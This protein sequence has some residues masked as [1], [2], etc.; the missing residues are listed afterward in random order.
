LDGR[1]DWDGSVSVSGI[2]PNSWVLVGGPEIEV[3]QGVAE[4]VEDS[5]STTGSHAYNPKKR[6]S[7]LAA[8][9]LAREQTA[10]AHDWVDP[11][12]HRQK[13]RKVGVVALEGT[14]PPGI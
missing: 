6:G 10:C 2:S 5:S 3:M 11:V 14:L 9:A 4:E 13:K 1:S 8:D 12:D 7:P